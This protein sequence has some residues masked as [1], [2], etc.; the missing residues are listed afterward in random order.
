MSYEELTAAMQAQASVPIDQAA[1][2]RAVET[3]L[4]DVNVT[5]SHVKHKYAVA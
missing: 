3:I 1:I 2:R 5:G 4:E